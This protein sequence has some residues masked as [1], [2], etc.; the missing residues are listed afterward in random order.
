M[1]KKFKIWENKFNRFQCSQFN[2]KGKGKI[3]VTKRWKWWRKWCLTKC[4]NSSNNSCS[5]KWLNKWPQWMYSKIQD[6]DS[7]TL[8]HNKTKWDLKLLISIL[9]INP[10]RCLRCRRCHKCNKCSKCHKCRWCLTLWDNIL[11]RVKEILNNFNN[12]WQIWCGRT[13]WVKILMEKGSKIL[14]SYSIKCRVSRSNSQCLNYQQI[15]VIISR[16]EWIG[17]KGICLNKDNL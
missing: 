3:L 14:K 16:I 2:H 10:H 8:K 11:S 6:R 17:L 15:I 1:S 12:K 5:N 4:S 13:K 9:T 7:T